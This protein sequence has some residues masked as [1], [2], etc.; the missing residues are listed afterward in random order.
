MA[1]KCV[2]SDIDGTLL[3]SKHQISEKTKKK[4]QQLAIQNIPFVLVSARMPKGMY[5]FLD[6]LQIKAPM[7]SYSGG[8][9]LDENQKVIYS[10]GFSVKMAK[11]LYKY[12]KYYYQIPVNFYVENHWMVDEIDEGIE[13][14]SIITGV[15][16]EKL[17][18]NGIK[19][20]HKL[21]VI[22]EAGIVDRL[23]MSLKE[24]FSDLKI[25]KSKDT[26]LEIMDQFHISR[27]TARRDIVR[28]V[29]ENLAV[30]THGGI[31]LNDV[32]QIGN[33]QTRKQKNEEIKNE[34]GKTAVS[35]IENNKVIFFDTSTTVAAL[36]Q[37]V[38][39]D[40]EAYSHSLDNIEILSNHCLCQMIGG[41][42]FKKNRYMYGS[43][44]LNMIDQ[45]YFDLAYV[46]A[47]VMEDGIYVEE[48]EDAM[49]KKKVASRSQK[50]CLV[51]DHSKFNKKS[52][53]KALAFQDIDV[54][55]VD[56]LPDTY[57][58]KIE[59]AGCQIIYTK[60]K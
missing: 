19:K 21:L 27:D 12:I 1:Y 40:I 17:D 16:P 5:Y 36:C 22:A 52:S 30:R 39:S 10:K 43:Q 26:Y 29:S 7:V 25:Y 57:R 13:E 58:E 28:L 6:E 48:F 54:L 37:Y 34:I 32:H 18:L 44:T 14:E 38:E 53:Y 20:V 11:R 33:Y 55:V 3:N 51:V 35:L 9:I 47:A 2:F 31:T 49:I 15:K 46:A 41:T 59:Q 45:I 42:Y 8:L 4:V 60:E 50:V 23:E 56:W 24:K